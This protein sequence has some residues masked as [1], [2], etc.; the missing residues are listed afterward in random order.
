MRYL[1][2]E[3]ETIITFDPI[4]NEWKA[5]S[6]I[7][8]HITKLQ[9]QGWTMTE[10]TESDGRIIDAWF[11]AP[12]NAIMFRDVKKPLSPN[13]YKPPKGTQVKRRNATSASEIKTKQST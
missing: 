5:W 11:T 13:R 2:E 9:K 12:T 4:I 1:E 10:H 6:T 3:R 7:P 8:K